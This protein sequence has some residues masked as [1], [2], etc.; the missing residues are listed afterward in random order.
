MT[1]EGHRMELDSAVC[2]S[3]DLENESFSLLPFLI[4][5]DISI[6]QVEEIEKELDFSEKFSLVFLLYENS[7]LELAY[8]KL[9]VAHTAYKACDENFFPV[10]QWVREH[11]EDSEWNDYLLEALCII[12]NYKLVHKLGYSKNDM[13]LKYLP[14]NPGLSSKIDL[15]RKALYRLCEVLTVGKAEK[16]IDM[17]HADIA[18]ESVETAVLLKKYASEFLEINLLHWHSLQYITIA[19]SAA[20]GDVDIQKL[21]RHLKVLEEEELCEY[22]KVIE[23][24]CKPEKMEYKSLPSEQRTF[25]SRPTLPG[26]GDHSIV[27]TTYGSSPSRSSIYPINERSVGLCLII[28]Q[29]YFFED[30][31]PNLQLQLPQHKLETRLG[32]DV[33]EARLVEA[34]L[35]LGFEI[36]EV[37][38]NL[39]HTQIIDT[40][41]LTAKKFRKEHSC[42]AV[43]ILSHGKKDGVYGSNSIAVQINEI[44]DLVSGRINPYLLGKPK[45]IIIQ[46]CQGSSLQSVYVESCIEEDGLPRSATVRAE[47]RTRSVLSD[48]IKFWST[49]PGFASFRH[50][51]NGT[52]FIEILASELLLQKPKMDICAIFT[53]VNG[54]LNERKAFKNDAWVGMTPQ[55]STTLTKTLYLPLRRESR[56][57]VASKMLL[58][59]M[60]N[61]MLDEYIREGIRSE[62]GEL[63]GKSGK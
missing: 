34:F 50:P 19:S 3:P 10:S 57:P 16:L 32:T 56:F 22:V 26:R 17:V 23:K 25:L 48:Q 31:D 44:E 12:Q 9:E 21:A 30:E 59:H 20:R 2:S 40:V 37:G 47:D 51:Q 36:S 53:V 55:W 24:R 41:Y 11:L 1:S 42:L 29:K 49:V 45:I 52:W 46:A 33:D 43:C 27:S 5:N 54:K 8:Q 14:D 35:A 38:Q 63:F 62:G 58:R 6:S 39:T 15:M 4:S 18:R 13:N 7:E 28:N 61:I 60:F